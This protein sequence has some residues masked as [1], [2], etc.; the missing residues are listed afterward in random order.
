M[1]KKVY[2]TKRFMRLQSYNYEMG[3]VPEAYCNFNYNKI[4]EEYIHKERMI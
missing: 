4:Y 2:L 1:H 3:D